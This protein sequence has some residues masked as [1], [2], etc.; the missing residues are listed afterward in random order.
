MD[1]IWHV[2]VTQIRTGAARFG[3]EKICPD[4]KPR[5]AT[6]PQHSAA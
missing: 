3:Y 4:Y 1:D 5:P 6:K 2:S